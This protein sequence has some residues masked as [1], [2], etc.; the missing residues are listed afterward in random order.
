MQFEN[1]S[2][3]VRAKRV[4]EFGPFRLDAAERL[5]LRDGEVVPLTLKAFDTLVLLVDN[6]GHLLEREALL[7][8]VWADSFV[9]EAN[10]TVCISSL[11]KALGEQYNGHQ[12]IETVPKRAYRFAADVSLL[13]GKQEDLILREQIRAQVTI[14][15]EEERDDQNESKSEIETQTKVY[16]VKDPQGSGEAGAAY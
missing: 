6:G 8:S 5:Q 14:E 12:Y 1:E 10:L 11:R 7:K 13:G 3:R 16:Q 2:L 4:Y 15:Q 9:E